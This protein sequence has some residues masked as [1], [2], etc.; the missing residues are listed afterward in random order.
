MTIETKIAK[1]GSKRYYVRNENG[2][3]SRISRQD[4]LMYQ[5]QAER[6]EQWKANNAHKPATVEVEDYTV[7]TE[8]QEIAIEAET[9]LANSNTDTEKIVAKAEENATTVYVTIAVNS[10]N[11]DDLEKEELEEIHNELEKITE[12]KNFRCN[13]EHGICATVKSGHKASAVEK[14]FDNYGLKY[15]RYAFTKEEPAVEAETEQAQAQ[16]APTVVFNEQ[17]FDNFKF[18]TGR[19]YFRLNEDGTPFTLKVEARTAHMLTG[20]TSEGTRKYKVAE[21]MLGEYVQTGKDDGYNEGIMARNEFIPAIVEI[22]KVKQEAF[23]VWAGKTPN[24]DTEPEAPD[25]QP[26]VTEKFIATQITFPNG[27]EGEPTVEVSQT[28]DNLDDAAKFIADDYPVIDDGTL[29]SLRAAY[30]DSYFGGIFFAGWRIEHG[31]KE[32]ASVDYLGY[33]H[34]DEEAVSLVDKYINENDE[35]IIPDLPGFL[36]PEAQGDYNEFRPKVETV[37]VLFNFDEALDAK[38]SLK[39]LANKACVELGDL[40]LGKFDNSLKTCEVLAQVFG[41]TNEIDKFKTLLTDRIIIDKPADATPTDN[42]NFQPQD[43]R[44]NRLDNVLKFPCGD[45][46]PVK[47]D[48]LRD[49]KKLSA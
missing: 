23:N 28:F 25:N 21:N 33:S 49:H 31:G 13:A 43:A 4:A 1:N 12:G 8:A 22:A 6:F 38:K 24:D 42:K 41:T 26:N 11:P 32:L 2:K 37:K 35:F 34:G 20:T 16:T 7:S 9:E 27:H 10:P 3:L 44:A 17:L 47:S 18:E 45:F 14:L 40:T 29:G 30:H 5:R 15:H 39:P 19:T 36:A 48:S 46:N